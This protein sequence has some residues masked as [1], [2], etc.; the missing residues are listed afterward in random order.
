MRRQLINQSIWNCVL[1]NGTHVYTVVYEITPNSCMCFISE[2]SSRVQTPP[3]VED[4]PPFAN[5]FENS[6]EKTESIIM[7]PDG[8]R[9]QDRLCW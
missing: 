7:C 6:F 2:N 8:I 1:V 3:L 9:K 4:E 5:N